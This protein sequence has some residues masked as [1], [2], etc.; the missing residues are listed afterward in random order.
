MSISIRKKSSR[1]SRT[2]RHRPRE[3]S[4]KSLEEK[5]GV[6][7][8]RRAV[9]AAPAA[10]GGG[11]ALRSAEEKTEFTVVLKAGGGNRDWRH[12]GRP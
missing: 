4:R 2:H 9:A 11:A 10:G 7:A 8:G 3:T 6:K 5:W 12:E 1:T